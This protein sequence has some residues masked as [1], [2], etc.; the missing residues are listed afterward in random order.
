MS[1]AAFAPRCNLK[2]DEKRKE[3]L[4]KKLQTGEQWIVIIGITCTMLS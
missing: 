3:K 4:K 1:A 2:K